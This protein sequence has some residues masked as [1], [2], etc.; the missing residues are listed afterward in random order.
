VSVGSKHGSDDRASVEVTVDV[1]INALATDEIPITI[2]VLPQSGGAA[3]DSVT[4]TV[5]VAEYHAMDATALSTDQT[6]RSATEVRF[7]IEVDN[8]GNVQDTMRFA[9]IS[10]TAFPAWGT[11]FETESG[12]PFT[13]ID[14]APRS[15]L[16]VYFVVSIDGEEELEYSRFTV[17]I[18]NKDD[19]NS[20]DDDEDGL[21]DN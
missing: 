1:P 15:T 3:Y 12:T 5:T 10:Q 2:S 14:I 11:H 6:G 18:T 20:A 7:P 19:P 21:L 9:M 16:T 4:F 8:Q 17:R 13:E